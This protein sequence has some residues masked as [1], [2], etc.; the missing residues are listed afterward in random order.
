MKLLCLGAL[1][2]PAMAAAQVAEDHAGNR[3][4]DFPQLGQSGPPEDLHNCTRDNVWCARLQK[5]PATGD[6]ILIVNARAEG[7]NRMDRQ[8]RYPVPS[9]Y[10]C[11]VPGRA[12]G[13]WDQIVREAFGGGALVGFELQKTTGE[14]PGFFSFQRRLLL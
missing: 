12:F 7:D 13:I 2:W 5:D 11:G 8:W 6:W 10:C 4:E 3:I 9:D 1:L 14:R